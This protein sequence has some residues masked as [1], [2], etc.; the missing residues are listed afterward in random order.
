ML[1]PPTEAHMVTVLIL[2]M[3]GNQKVLQG[4]IQCLDVHIEF[5]RNGLVGLKVTDARNVHN[6]LILS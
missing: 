6:S 1:L 3:R 5:H 4:G 2:L